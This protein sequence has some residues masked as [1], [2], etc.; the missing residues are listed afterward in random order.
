[1]S[2][3]TF[4][5][6]VDNLYADN[7]TKRRPAVDPKVSGVKRSSLSDQ[8]AGN[9]RQAILAGVLPPGTRMLEIEL[10]QQLGV[11]RGPLREALRIL[12]GEGLV[13]AFP[14]RGVFVASLDEQDIQELYSLRELLETYAIRL[15]TE[16]ADAAQ[17]ARLRALV[18][19]MLKAAK[20]GN[21]AKVIDL[22]LQFH[23]AVWQL[24]GHQRLRQMLTD[25][26]SQIRIFLGVNTQLYADLAEGVADH[27]RI[28]EAVE[29]KKAEVAVEQ[30]RRHVVEARQVVL[31][32]V[33]TMKERAARLPDERPQAPLERA[34]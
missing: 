21:H 14:N 24:S 3:A 31:E 13:E 28:I 1:V 17:T 23:Q 22:D 32:Y 18:D 20:T 33:R 10:A 16:R 9:L 25:M 12:Q 26:L 29:S 34:V 6:I 8:I 30:M 11:S 5:C 27:Q 7:T 19:E 2:G 4:C 15:A